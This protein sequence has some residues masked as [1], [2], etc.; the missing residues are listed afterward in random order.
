[1]FRGSVS[2]KEIL[3]S[4]DIPKPDFNSEPIDP[5][6]PTYCLC[7]QVSFGEMI[8]CD[9]EDVSHSPKQTP[10]ITRPFSFIISVSDRVVPFCVRWFNK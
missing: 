9:N 6:E 5:D 10:P 8:G 3:A 4:N 2:N 7:D 1:M